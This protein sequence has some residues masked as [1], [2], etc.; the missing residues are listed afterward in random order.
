MYD[1]MIVFCPYNTNK[2]SAICFLQAS[3]AFTLTLHGL[4]GLCVMMT[5]WSWGGT[6]VTMTLMRVI[7]VIMRS[8]PGAGAAARLDLAPELAAVPAHGRVGR[9]GAAA[10]DGA[11]LRRAQGAAQALPLPRGG[12]VQPAAPRLVTC[13][14]PPE[15]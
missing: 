15:T 3:W 9:G 7:M 14:T 8:L 10:V 5:M 11:H 12:G 1:C 2:K 13:H 6:P 4:L